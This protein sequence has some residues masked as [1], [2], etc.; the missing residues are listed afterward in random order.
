MTDKIVSL[1]GR[2]LTINPEYEPNLEL[3]AELEKMLHL[4]KEGQMQA[5]FIVAYLTDQSIIS[6]WNNRNGAIAVY[7][8]L[9][10]VEECKHQYLMSTF[11]QRT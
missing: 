2:G 3:I 9:G 5:M 4:A 7:T 8:L 6:G 1:A 11:A 10:G